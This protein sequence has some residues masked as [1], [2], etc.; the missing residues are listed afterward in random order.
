MFLLL[1]RPAI[2]FY[3]WPFVSMA[4]VMCNVK[5]YNLSCRHQE[6]LGFVSTFH[7][8][9]AGLTFFFMLTAGSD[10]AVFIEVRLPYS[11]VNIDIREV[12]STI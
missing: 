8:G 2:Q 3:P 10:Y 12:Q 9:S 1:S 11:T 5:L 4:A 6:F 7:T